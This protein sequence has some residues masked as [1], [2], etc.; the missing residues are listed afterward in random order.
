MK[1]TTRKIA[2]A[3]AIV[4]AVLTVL[5][6]CGT[7]GGRPAA[8][9]EATAGNNGTDATENPQG[10]AGIDASEGPLQTES[11]VEPSD[12]AAAEQTETPETA[13]TGT[14]GAEPT[15]TPDHTETP[16]PTETPKPTDTPEPTAAPTAVPD[17]G[18]ANTAA[19]RASYTTAIDDLGRTLLTG[20][21]ES[22]E[23]KDRYVGIFYF[24]WIGYHD[25]GLRDNSA[26]V[27]QNPDALKSESNWMAAGGGAVNEFHF[28]G[29]PM[30]DYYP[31][32]DKWVM[33]KHVQ[34][35]TDA[36]IDFLCFDATNA[37]TY[38]QNALAMMKILK[39]YK[40][41]GFSVPKVAFYTNS[42]SGDT[43]NR[44]YNEIYKA[45]PEY[46][47]IWFN[48]DGK[49]M[50]VG[51][52]NDKALSG[53][54][55]DFFR[56]KAS[57]WPNAGRTDDGFPWMEFGRL[58]SKDAIYGLNG[59][60]EV[61]NVSVAQHNQTCNFS[62]TAWYKTNDRTRSWHNGRNDKSDNAY[63]YGYNF[64]EQFEWAI[65]VDPE[66]IFI[67]GWNE[68]IAQ[69]QPVA[70][71]RKPIR[72]VDNADAN[73]SR[74]I[75]PMEG[76]YGDNYY[77][78]MISFIRKYKGA[79]GGV[80]GDNKAIDMDGGFAQWSSVK[81]LY[82]DYVND[83]VNR[84][85]RVFVTKKDTTGRNDFDELKVCEDAGNIYFFAKTAADIT[86][87]G[88]ND[89]AKNT[90]MTLYISTDMG[91]GWKGANFVINYAAPEGG[92][93][94]VGRLASSDSYSVAKC[95]DAQ[96]RYR[97]NMMMVAVPKAALG[98]SGSA[99]ISFKWADNTAVG[100]VFSFYKNGD[101]API[102]RAFYRYGA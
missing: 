69:R 32:S 29:K 66:M 28:W 75:E 16:D 43:M 44:I 54:A 7:I 41:A 12:T 38:T 95:G 60:K 84:S 11:G 76:G 53:E 45:H 42:S 50:I 71:S 67:T 81:A 9:T 57:V 52:A 55:K 35:L 8:P 40:D 24:L 90:W 58:L 100:D 2:T 13:E 93:T 10:T 88:D 68:W 73:C 74:D 47:S 49:P 22:T 94:A 51:D 4:L 3:I 99:S 23:R 64:A 56:I 36:G 65:G 87:A 21:A 30:F 31:S 15:G 102:G 91:G 97:G 98:I 37:F 80:A 48:W 46:E 63:L 1:N 17:D 92:K 70:D 19:Y 6:G 27:A 33:R 5:S 101:A 86:S 39:E 26:I 59:R 89:F 20:N 25:S 96:I 79:P 14:A 85:N 83:T 82:R 34:M 78:Q 72:F 18:Y 77:M 62:Y 61:V